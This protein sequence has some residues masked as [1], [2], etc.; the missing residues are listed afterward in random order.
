MNEKEEI[1]RISPE[2]DE[3][4]LQAFCKY[5]II[6]MFEI[7]A[8]RGVKIY[9]SRTD[10]KDKFHTF[11]LDDDLYSLLAKEGYLKE[12]VFEYSY[13]DD[14][15]E[16]EFNCNLLVYSLTPKGYSILE[17][18]PQLNHYDLPF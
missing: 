12:N 1:F 18:Y 14:A 5:A 3:A 9:D 4:V 13:Y 15:Y 8:K 6:K 17:K 11:L 10:F 7:R 16:E 2:A